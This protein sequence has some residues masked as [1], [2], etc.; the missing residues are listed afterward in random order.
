MSARS[1]NSRQV[2]NIGALLVLVVVAA[3]VAPA[4]ATD[5]NPTVRHAAKA[6]H[7]VRYEGKVETGGQLHFKAVKTDGRI[8]EV[9]RFGWGGVPITCE[10]GDTAHG[11]VMR[12]SMRVKKRRFA[13]VTRHN[14]FGDAT[15]KVDGRFIRKHRAKGHLRVIGNFHGPYFHCDTGTLTWRAKRQ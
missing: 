15:H 11:G 5:A 7:I 2:A 10:G 14:T 1:W 4:L 6:S 13:K 12:G 3:F 9:R 8:V